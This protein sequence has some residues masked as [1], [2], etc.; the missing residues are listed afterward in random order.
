MRSP[1][2][3]G[4]TSGPK[5]PLW[6]HALPLLAVVGLS[7][8]A[9]WPFG[10]GE[11]EEPLIPS[12]EP[13]G[14]VVDPNI[15]R[16]EVKVPEIDTE[17]FEVGY[18]SGILSTE[19]LQ[20]DVMFGVRGAYHI[21]DLLF[22]EGRYI[23]STVSDEIRRTIGQPFF[24]EEQM[25]LDSY[26][27]DA[28]FNLLPGEVFLGTRYAMNSSLYMLLG[29][30]NTSFNDEDYLTYSF[31]FGLKVLPMDWWS[32]RLEARD[33]LWES[34][35]LGEPKLTHNFEMSFGFALFF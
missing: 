20:S 25:D 10:G 18:F 1:I 24:P 14:Q 17:N 26:A 8:C 13:P 29:A 35:L 12:E 9:L 15:E 6:L 31:G 28:G 2:L 22:L 4:G 16:R 23:R 32:I 30:G 27:I 3:D 7:G 11:P 5:L 34:D 33:N 19:D 21:T